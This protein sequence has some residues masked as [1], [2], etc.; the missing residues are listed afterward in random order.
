MDYIIHSGITKL[1][2][3]WVYNVL[4]GKLSVSQICHFTEKGDMALRYILFVCLAIGGLGTITGETIARSSEPECQDKDSRCH[5]WAKQGHCHDPNVRYY[6]KRSCHRCP[7]KYQSLTKPIM[8]A[9]F[10]I[11]IGVSKFASSRCN[12]CSNPHIN[13]SELVIIFSLFI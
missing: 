9:T 1:Y 4:N 2:H 7:S 3:Q 5:T 10:S 12:A 6:C 13:Y 8:A 11:F